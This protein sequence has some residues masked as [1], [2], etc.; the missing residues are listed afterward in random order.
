MWDSVLAAEPEPHVALE[1]ERVDRALTAVGD[2]ADL[3]SPR[4]SGHS[5]GVAKLAGRAAVLA[6]LPEADVT[7]TGRAGLVQDVGRASVPVS[8]WNRPGRLTRGEWEKV[9][10]HPYFT[11]RVCAGSPFLRQ[12]GSYAA[13]HHERVD[14]SGYHRGIGAELL[15]MATRLLAAADML[16]ALTQSR[17]HRGPLGLSEAIDLLAREV[18]SGRLDADAVGA[19][20]EAAG[21]EPPPLPRP[22]GLT[23]R[24]AQIVGLLA[25]GLA[26]KQ[27]A[28][29]LG[30]SPKTVDRH[31]EHAYRKIGVSSRAGVTLFATEH[32]LL[33][34]GELP[35]GRGTARS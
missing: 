6:G 29:L 4:F 21:G 23:D 2:F 13:S 17:P 24:E 9:R 34:W 14:G 7:R 10:L 1:G 22:A 26:T 12:L 16:H 3:L 11:E 18:T 33:A 27:V 15:P 8:A 31:T 32:G 30:I 5:Q 19:V 35:I 20:V 25:R 28:R